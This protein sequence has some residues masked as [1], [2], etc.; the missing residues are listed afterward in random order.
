MRLK[1]PI[2][3]VIHRQTRNLSWRGQSWGTA[4]LALDCRW[5]PPEQGFGQKKYRNFAQFFVKMYFLA[6]LGRLLPPPPLSLPGYACVVIMSTVAA[7][8]VYL[9]AGKRVKLKLDGYQ[10]SAAQWCRCL[11]SVA[12][13][14]YKAAITIAIR[15]RFGYDDSY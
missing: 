1:P 11:Y 5:K 8:W 2:I 10:S 3:I 4:L 15:L 13:V 7:V 12:E 9:L 14:T 6:S